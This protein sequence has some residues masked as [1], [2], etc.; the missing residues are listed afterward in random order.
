MNDDSGPPTVLTEEEEGQLASYLIKMADM[1]FGLS[2]DDV[3]L[4][5]YKIAEHSGRSHPFAKGT[6]G[7]SW[8]DIFRSRHANL[9]LRSAQSLS[10]SRAVCA[11][12][13]IVLP[14]WDKANADLQH[15]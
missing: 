1:G 10:H 13:E 3:M 11:N 2:R 9:S 15:G 14:N 7:R 5:A 6:A 4:T 12:E 8:F